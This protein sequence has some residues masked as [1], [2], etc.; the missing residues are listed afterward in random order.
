MK[1][2]HTNLRMTKFYALLITFIFL[3]PFTL[4]AQDNEKLDQLLDKLNEDDGGPLGGDTAGGNGFN[5][6]GGYKSFVQN[7]LQN[8]YAQFDKISEQDQSD[9]TFKE[10]NKKR[11]ELAGELCQRDERAC[12]LIDEYRSYQSKQD[13]PRSFEELELFGHDIF[14]GYSNDFNFY[15]SLPLGESYIIKIGDFLKISLFG[16]FTFNQLL[17][18]DMNGSIIIQDIG[19]FQVAGLTFKDASSKIKAEIS[20]KYVGTEAYVTLDQIRS[21]QI[22]ALGNVKTPGTYALNA[23]GSPLNALIS[24]GGVEQN[25]SL[26][27]I[28]VIRDNSTVQTID[29]YDLLIKGDTTTS[30]F[31]LGDGDTI[32]IGGLQS[33]ISIIGEIIRP[34]IY[35]IIENNSLEDALNFALGVT[36]F[37]DI[38][39][40]SVER[41]LSTGQ[42]TIIKPKDISSFLLRN[43]D[44]VVVNSLKGN[45]VNSVSL[46]GAV[47]NAGEY[48]LL[49][50][51]NLGNIINIQTDL[52]DNTYTGFGILKRLNYQSKSYRLINFSL[53]DQSELDKINLYSGDKVFIFSQQDI[54]FSQSKEVAGY[55]FSKLNQSIEN[56]NLMT[57]SVID[58]SSIINAE[59][60]KDLDLNQS[61]KL[62]NLIEG[63]N[64]CLIALD[65]LTE[66]PISNLI[67]AKLDIF[68]A[69]T[70][71]K[72]TSLFQK[73]SDLLPI[74][75]INSIP[76]TGNVRFPG[77]YPTSSNLNAENLF[78]IAG[79]FLVS[80]LNKLPNFDVG[81]RSRGFGSFEY[82][83]LKNLTNITMLNLQLDQSSMQEGYV[84]LI[85]EFA[86]PGT[87]VIN[88]DT[89][90]SDL[91]SRAGGITNQAYPLG[92]I[93]T[94]A[95]VK[96]SERKALERS[97]G[98]L[99]EILASAVASGY[100]KQSSTDLVGLISMMSAI[101]GSQPVG[102]LVT[103]LNPSQFRTNPSLDIPLENGDVIYMP[104]MNNTVTVVGQ[105]LNPVTVPHKIGISFNDYIEM[106]GGLKKEADK[107]KIYA[108]LP[109]GVSARKKI[110]LTLPL[111]PYQ[112]FEKN[113]IL[114]GTTII[115]PRKARPLDSIALIETVT[116]I[117]ANLSV[118][119]ASIAAISDN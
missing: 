18:V 67:E 12:F 43:G 40:I 62:A 60:L 72:C 109:N 114:P 118:T 88:K 19:E 105:V 95:S 94:R 108:I 47:R 37:A 34:A 3:L 74:L 65:V 78:N 107:A 17:K 85:G 82:E 48:S 58:V 22:Y 66:N 26:R 53:T 2:S 70:S 103:E 89:K 10:I 21:K 81:I 23:F 33:R 116:P 84:K 27:S 90:L 93:L 8:I 14:S 50:T 31:V 56:N 42:T 98:E 77:L 13:I 86:K 96:E 25:S 87:F 1:I 115:V 119:A 20:S 102:R 80:K 46:L 97:K 117:L 101:E 61:S 73:H 30:D 110:G 36:P 92:G 75:L 6:D 9:L 57:N 11:I 7:E 44:R 83:D 52:L 104:K 69:N 71:M 49:D 76:V 112:P 111:L 55:F 45:K 35:E 91:Y 38:T 41:I 79:G 51:K 100:L 15:D 68:P 4:V 39:N 32:L 59:E 54:A 99:T 24:A 64:N 106:A 28:K 5:L 113:D 29:L 16:G 63:G